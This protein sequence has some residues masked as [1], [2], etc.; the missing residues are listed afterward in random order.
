MQNLFTF[1]KKVAQASCN[2]LITG[3]SGTGKEMVARAIHN[4]GPRAK[5]PF[6][7][8][9]CAAIPES[10]L[11]SEL[12]GHTKGSFTG[13]TER[14]RGLFEEANEGTLF[15]DEIG[16][17]P[18]PLQAKLLRFL[19][20]RT[21]KSV[22][23]NTYRSLDVRVMAATHQN[24]EKAIQEGKFR[25]D[26]YYRLCVAPVEIPPLRQRREDIL[27]LAEHF[28]SKFSRKSNT[29]VLGFTKSALAKLARLPWP[30]NVR[31]LENIIERA[32]IF[33]EGSFIDEHD[34]QVTDLPE[35]ASPP[36]TELFSR[37]MSLESLEREYIG[38]V[39]Q[40]TGNKREAAAKILGVDRKTLYRKQRTYGEASSASQSAN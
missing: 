12:F 1:V 34:I 3:E 33:S 7:A 8:I 36:T 16:D 14:R 9:N 26:L 6:I 39:L 40:Q 2:L 4:L 10:L 22:G 24:L 17:M 31:E 19:Q 32:V 23:E 29:K 25:Q 35:S 5:K 37:L 15:L 21:V 30:G 27:L 18:L 20:E 38:Y 28:L 11:E 13:A